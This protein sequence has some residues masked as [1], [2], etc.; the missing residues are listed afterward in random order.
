M[1]SVTVGSW[2]E[3]VSRGTD[4]AMSGLSQM[5]GSEIM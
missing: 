2:A 3:L 5:V 4:N 1:G